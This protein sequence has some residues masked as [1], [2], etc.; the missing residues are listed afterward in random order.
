[1]VS[2]IRLIIEYLY[3]IRRYKCW[4]YFL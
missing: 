2:I 3:N 1:M 4:Q